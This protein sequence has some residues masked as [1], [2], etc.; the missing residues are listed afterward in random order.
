MEM[1]LGKLFVGIV[2]AAACAVLVSVGLQAQVGKSLGVVDAN[3][4]SEAD[5]LKM[6]HMT[7]VI[8]KG[9]IDKRNFSSI[10][11]LNAYLLGAGLTQEQAMDFYTR[12]FVFVN[13]NTAAR[14]EI[15]LIPGAGRRMTIE[16]SEYRPW[17]TFAQFDKEIGKYVGQDATDKLKQY[18]F[19]PVDLNTATDE[20][21]LGI[22]GAG[23]RMV[24]EFK[25]YRPWKTKA[26]FD[27]EISKYVGQKE[28]DRLWRFVVIK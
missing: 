6:P 17:R 20:D 10:V 16:F 28:T 11:D 7:P 23:A 3:L 18:V 27:K 2:G 25:E 5:L 24:R 22:P 21:I 15:L 8:A 26:Q 4:V 9:L 1:G 12:A 19:I 13:L 14:E